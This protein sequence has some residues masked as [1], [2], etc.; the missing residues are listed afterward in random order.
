MNRAN[1]KGNNMDDKDII[2]LYFSRD[3]KAL[4]YTAQKYDS[5]CY[6][7]AHRILGSEEDA[8]EC[9]NDVL[10]AAWD[11]I[12]PNRPEKLSLYLGK[13]AKNLSVNKLRTINAKKRGAD[14]VR[15]CLDELGEVV[16]AENDPTALLE[17]EELTRA[18]ERGL[19]SVSATNRRIFISRY[20]YLESVGEIASRFCMNENQV[21]LRLHRT[22][23]KLRKM[24]RKEGLTDE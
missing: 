15:V 5:Y 13:I 6:A 4:E 14:Y 8:K 3:E 11:S 9:V 21:K 20:Y 18:I 10:L 24:L 16:P 7:I 17:S 1:F 12:P 19:K 22:R 2:D 23:E